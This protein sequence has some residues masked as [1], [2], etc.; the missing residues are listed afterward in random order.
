MSDGIAHIGP[1][2]VIKLTIDGKEYSFTTI[3]LAEHAEKE[4]YIL[5][6]R[7]DALQAL[8]TLPATAPKHVQSLVA[9]AAMKAAQRP[10][11]VTRDEE[12][13]FDESLHGMAWRIWRS[14]RENHTEFGM[15]TEG[16]QIKH[17]VGSKTFTMSPADGVQSALTF[18]ETI[19]NEQVG[20]V[21][22]A[23]GGTEQAELVGN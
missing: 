1:P 21:I 20:R 13:Q 3:I 4:A 17:K 22:N 23:V 12:A 19:G 7:P 5:S 18:M 10:A 11:F 15:P 16:A 8:A 2:R 14:L 6:L 9:D